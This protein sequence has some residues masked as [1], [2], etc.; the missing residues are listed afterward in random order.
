MHIGR[1]IGRC[2]DEPDGAT[3]LRGIERGAFVW[4]PLTRPTPS[5]T[6]HDTTV[7]WPGSW[8]RIMR[9]TPVFTPR[10]S[11]GSSRRWRTTRWTANWV[12]E[13]GDGRAESPLETL[14]RM[15]F[16]TYQREVP[17]SN[18]WF[19]VGPRRYRVD[20]YLPDDGIAIE[21]DGGTKYNDR[22]DAHQ[23]VNAEKDRERD[24]RSVGV[25]FARY[26]YEVA[27]HRPMEILRRVDV[28]KRIRGN[29]PL[30]NCWSLDPP[31]DLRW[32]RR[33]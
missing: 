12:V 11:R 32:A 23:V 20:H 13:H 4:R 7:R 27:M 18:V 3:Y 28:A 16:L 33:A 2:T 29:R 31:E 9:C 19:A 6:S 25:E 22:P 1:R 5:S 8:R 15:A 24:L 17:L 14:G 30:P 10:F 21:G 26:N